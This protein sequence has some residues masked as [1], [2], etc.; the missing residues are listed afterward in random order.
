[1]LDNTLLRK[2]GEGFRQIGGFV[3]E[4]MG[5]IGDFKTRIDL[6]LLV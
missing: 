2:F 5:I 1:M 3:G 4:I 6:P